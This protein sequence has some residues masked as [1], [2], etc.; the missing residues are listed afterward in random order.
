MW[1]SVS[2]GAIFIKQ[3]GVGPAKRQCARNVES[4]VIDKEMPRFVQ[5]AGG[6][7]GIQILLML[8]FTFECVVSWYVTLGGELQ[9]D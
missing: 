4:R 8:R 9:C 7:H 6:L 1:R 5:D 3:N 2:L